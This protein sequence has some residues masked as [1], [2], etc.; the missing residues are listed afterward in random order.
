M[1]IVQSYRDLN[2]WKKSI[3]FIKAIYIESAAFPK[4]EQYG[5]TKQM[6]RSAV[7]IAADIAEGHARQSTKEFLYF[8]NVAYG[9]LAETETHLVIA[10]ELGFLPIEKLNSILESSAEIG[11]MLNG[12]V[13]ALKAKINPD[14]RALSPAPSLENLCN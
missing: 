4:H 3:Q 13:R 12:L 7:S 11:R 9:S 2:V 5:L 1:T 14:P 6:Q 8:L 10:S